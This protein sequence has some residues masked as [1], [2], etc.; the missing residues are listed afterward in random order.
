VYNYVYFIDYFGIISYKIH[1]E[2]FEVERAFIFG[3]MKLISLNFKSF[4]R[5][6]CCS[7]VYTFVSFANDWSYNWTNAAHDPSDAS[8][9]DNIL[10]DVFCIY[11]CIW[12]CII[13]ATQKWRD[14]IGFHDFSTNFSSSLLVDDDF[15]CEIKIE[16]RV[17]LL[18]S[19]IFLDKLMILMKLKVSTKTSLSRQT[20]T[21]DVV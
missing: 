4:S 20:K 21:I 5:F 12:C 7:L 2:C 6:R 17:Y 18:Y 10:F 19:G 3:E 8:W 16:S 14:L 15:V 13:C 1:I 11:I 9:Y